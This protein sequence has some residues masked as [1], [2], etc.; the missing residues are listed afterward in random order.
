MQVIICQLLG[1][2]WLILITYVL[3]QIPLVIIILT[4]K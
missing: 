2:L 3:L 1:I 4:R